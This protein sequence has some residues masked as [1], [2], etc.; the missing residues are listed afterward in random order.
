[1]STAAFVLYVFSGLVPYM[2]IMQAMNE[3][4]SAIR[5]N[6]QLVRNVILAVNLARHS[7]NG[8]DD[9]ALPDDYDEIGR[10]LH[11]NS[12]DIK[13]IVGANKYYVDKEYC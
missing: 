2:A 4:S 9:A 12:D 7:A 3:G 6:I 10:L 5:G 8:W 1:M 13:T 11:L